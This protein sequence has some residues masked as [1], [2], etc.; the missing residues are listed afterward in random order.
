MSIGY[1]SQIPGNVLLT[2]H[3]SALPTSP[4]RARANIQRLKTGSFD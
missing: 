2:E 4:I 3:Q 1:L